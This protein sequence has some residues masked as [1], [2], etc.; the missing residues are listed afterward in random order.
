METGGNRRAKLDERS[1]TENALDPNRRVASFDPVW[2]DHRDSARRSS[3]DLRRT[4]THMDNGKITG[5][6]VSPLNGYTSTGNRPDRLDGRDSGLAILRRHGSLDETPTHATY[7]RARC[8][9]TDNLAS[10]RA[11]CRDRWPGG[12]AVPEWDAWVDG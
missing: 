11:R 7:L 12:R 1:F 4:R 9:S 8:S 6:E 10:Y 3:Y 2:D 5:N